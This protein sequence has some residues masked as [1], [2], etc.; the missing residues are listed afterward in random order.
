MRTM[1]PGRE[2]VTEPNLSGPLQSFPGKLGFA[3]DLSRDQIEASVCMRDAVPRRAHGTSKGPRG[4]EL[5][6]FQKPSAVWSTGA[7]EVGTRAGQG[8]M[9]R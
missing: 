4:M 3:R 8:A 7:R 9:L 2:G 1:G 6:V 5:S